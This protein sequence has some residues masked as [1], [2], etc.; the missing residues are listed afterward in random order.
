MDVAGCRRKLR[1]FIAQPQRVDTPIGAIMQSFPLK[2]ETGHLYFMLGGDAWMFDTGSPTSF[3]AV[4]AISIEGE[5]FKIPS[6]YMGMDAVQLS[7]FAHHPTCGLLGGDIINQFDVRIAVDLGE[8]QFSKEEL[9][10]GG[11]MIRLDQFMGIPLLDV[12]IGGKSYRMFFD[13][14]A[15]VSYFQH[16]SLSSYPS[17]GSLPDFY[18][19]YGQFETST[20]HLEAQ[21][22]GQAIRLRCGDLPKM[23]AAGLVMGG[24]KGIVGNEILPGRVAGY[25]PRRGQLM[26]GEKLS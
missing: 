22:G 18:P 25:F 13:T 23:L 15:Q 9:S 16:H 1:R 26:L 12:A 6:A 24:A 14:G 10:A 5:E 21:I 8:I 17:A 7:G 3:G 20:H 2:F 4:D 11:A 19:G